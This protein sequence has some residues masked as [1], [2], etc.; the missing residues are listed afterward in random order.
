MIFPNRKEVICEMMNVK[1]VKR[2]WLGREAQ[3]DRLVRVL[4]AYCLR[5]PTSAKSALLARA[6]ILLLGFGHVHGAHKVSEEQCN[7]LTCNP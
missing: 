4:G 6:R 2:R 5:P 3:I 1:G 7:A